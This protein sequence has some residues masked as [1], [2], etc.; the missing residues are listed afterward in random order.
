MAHGVARST[1]SG[2]VR[3]LLIVGEALQDGYDL[4]PQ[5]PIPLLRSPLPTGSL[6]ESV[7]VH[8]VAKDQALLREKGEGRREERGVFLCGN[9]RLRAP[10]PAA[11]YRW[12][13]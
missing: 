7:L 9:A 8:E 4:T 5:F 11:W 3:H 10:E 1:L 2:T 13:P 6:V 12:V